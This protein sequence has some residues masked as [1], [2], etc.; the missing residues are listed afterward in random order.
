MGGIRGVEGVLWT[1]MCTYHK[2]MCP[3]Q[4][5]QWEDGE[6]KPVGGRGSGCSWKA[7]RLALDSW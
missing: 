1:D 6:G 5:G 7:G 3:H 4:Y 2:S